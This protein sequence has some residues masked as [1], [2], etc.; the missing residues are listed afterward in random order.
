MIHGRDAEEECFEM[1][2]NLETV[3]FHCYG[4]SIKTM[5]KITDAGH[6]ISVPTLVCF[7]EHHRDIARNIPLDLMLI[8]TDSPYLS[9]R[10]GRNEPAYLVDSVGVIAKFRDISAEEVATITTKNTKK[11][12]K[13]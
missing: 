5:E 6:Y 10:K 13:L 11:A 9:P 2:K 3:I 7:S 12:F 1:T 4:G 8:E